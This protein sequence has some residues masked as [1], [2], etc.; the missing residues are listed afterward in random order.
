MLQIS[1]ERNHFRRWDNSWM[2]GRNFISSA[3]LAYLKDFEEIQFT[4]YLFSSY[5]FLT[6]VERMSV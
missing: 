1:L 4:E 5:N 6:P 2:V 3:M